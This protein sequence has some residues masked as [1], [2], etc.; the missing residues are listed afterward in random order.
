M[1]TQHEHCIQPPRLAAWIA[2]LAAPAAERADLLIDLE[3]ELNEQ[4]MRLGPAAARRWYWRQV[5]RSIG[6]LVRRRARAAWTPA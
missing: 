4:A 3:D 5:F 6:P 1:P 2:R